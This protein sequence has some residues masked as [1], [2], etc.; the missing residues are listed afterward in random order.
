MVLSAAVLFLTGCS[1]SDDNPDN[2]SSDNKA[3]IS[4]LVL[5]PSS[6]LKY[7][8][9]VSLIGTLSDNVGLSTYT[10]TISNAGGSIYE[11][12]QPLTGK[13]FNLNESIVVP[14]YP[15]AV[16]GDLT[17]SLTVKN[18]GGQLTT[19]DVA[20]KSVS[21]PS[22]SKLY[23]VL[24]GTTYDMAKDGNVFTFEDFVSAGATGKIYANADKTGIFWG[25]GDGTTAKVLGT[26]DITF[27]KETEEFFKISFDPVSFNLTMGDPEQP[28]PMTGDDLYILGTISGHWMDNQSPDGITVEQ[29]KMKMTATKLGDRKIWTW[30]PPNDGTGDVATDM[31][32][33]TVAGVFRL[34]KAGQEQYI[35]YSGGKITTST[36]NNKDDNFIL[37]A[38]GQFN[39][40]VTADET[41]ITSIRAYDDNKQK[42]VEYQND[43]VLINGVVASSSVTFAGSTLNLVPGNYFVYQGTVDLTNGQSVTGSGIDLSPLYCDPD[44]FTGSGNPTWKVSAPT[45]TYYLRIDALSG[46]A[47]VKDAVGYPNAIYMDGWSWKKDIKDSRSNWNTGTELTLYRVGT[48]NIYEATCYIQPWSGDI[49]FF[50]APSTID[51]LSPGGMIPAPDFNIDASQIMTDGLG[52]LLP[53][54]DDPNGLYYKVSVN[55]KDGMTTDDNGYYIPSGAKFTCNFTLD[56]SLNATLSASSPYKKQFSFFRR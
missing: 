28:Q 27:G 50:A 47:F 3:V 8:D 20:V 44:V 34:K 1:K 36:S 4:N 29:N 32:G 31:W 10:I 42:S 6:N 39:I 37:S 14:L 48:S 21:L 35:V 7:G 16:A 54:P 56:N 53:V 40:R 25:L 23:L 46:F 55:L 30:T 24:N 18:S 51:N 15:N 45:S 41:G 2:G 43:K 52:I 38:A 26:G 22:F 12:T 9:V 13:S 33:N 19:Q 5:S 11:K 17:I 49:K